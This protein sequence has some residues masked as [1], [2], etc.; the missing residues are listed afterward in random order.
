MMI[1]YCKFISPEYP[2]SFA[3]CGRLVPNE[4]AYDDAGAITCR[5]CLKVMAREDRRELAKRERK[6][7]TL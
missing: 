3:D 5:Q 4:R 7:A 1:H 6:E 2:S